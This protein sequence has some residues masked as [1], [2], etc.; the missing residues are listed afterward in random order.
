MVR[1][2]R[3]AV[4]VFVLLFSVAARAADPAPAGAPPGD[5]NN[6]EEVI[7]RPARKWGWAF[8]A[9]ALGTLALGGVLGGVA[10]AR[11]DEQGGNPSAPTYYTQALLDRGNQGK[12]LADSAYA[13]FALGAALAVV[14]VVLWIEI[15]RK[16]TVRRRDATSAALPLGTVRF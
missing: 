4:V 12:A 8:G 3:R 15:L 2:M 9:A 6:K 10:L 1:R 13:F 5:A 14:D 11:A 16:P 7:P